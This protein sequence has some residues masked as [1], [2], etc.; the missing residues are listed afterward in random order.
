[1][2]SAAG[3]TLHDGILTVAEVA[4]RDDGGRD[5]VFLSACHTHSGRAIATDEMISLAAALSYTGWRD[6]VATLWSVYAER[7]AVTSE[8]FYRAVDCD[9]SGG[10]G[11]V[12]RA[13]HVAVHA[14]RAEDERPHRWGAFVHI[15]G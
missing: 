13:L 2:P 6:T 7:A 4:E 12:A 11:A 9:G 14:L 8:R 1:M 5:F 15:G 10:S 3:L